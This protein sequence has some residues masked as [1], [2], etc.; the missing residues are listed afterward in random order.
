MRMVS[1]D[2]LLWF[3]LS[4]LKRQR[5]VV[6]FTIETTWHFLPSWRRLAEYHVQII[7]YTSS[8]LVHK[9]DN[10]MLIGRCIDVLKFIP[11]L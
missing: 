1:K 2:H 6:M 10:Y 11:N 5:H 7:G 9:T 8:F 3:F 4:S